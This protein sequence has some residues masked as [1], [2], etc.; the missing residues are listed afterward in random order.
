[1]LLH[2]IKHHAKT[3]SNIRIT[4]FILTWRVTKME[5]SGQLHSPMAENFCTYRE[6]NPSSPARSS[7][8]PEVFY[9]I[10]YCTGNETDTYPLSVVFPIYH[11]KEQKNSL[12]RSRYC[13]K[14]NCYTRISCTKVEIALL[15]LIFHKKS[16]YNEPT[17]LL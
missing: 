6:L 1:M 8:Y 3:C 4:L 9:Y 16:S 12:L 17:V 11:G 14:R 7:R 15:K 13:R 10:T 5:M 2:F